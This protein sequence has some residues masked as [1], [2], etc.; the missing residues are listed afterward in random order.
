LEEV[1]G[2]V[3]ELLGDR[4]SEL[5]RFPI[6]NVHILSDGHLPEYLRGRCDNLRIR[7]HRVRF[8]RD[9]LQERT[10]GRLNVIV[11]QR[12]GL[13]LETFKDLLDYS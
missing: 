7:N 10:Y 9:V 4:L 12:R 3:V 13:F 6:G 8:K 11:G 2:E 5:K 1:I